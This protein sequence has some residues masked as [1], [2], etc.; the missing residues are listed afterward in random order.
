M[1]RIVLDPAHEAAIYR[2]K[3]IPYHQGRTD[4]PIDAAAALAACEKAAKAYEDMARRPVPKKRTAGV[5][6]TRPAALTTA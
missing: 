4:D 5:H 2:E 3:L 1:T 6:P